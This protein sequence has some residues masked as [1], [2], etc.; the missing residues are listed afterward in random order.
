MREMIQ[1]L[2]QTCL[3]LGKCI[4]MVFQDVEAINTELS[5]WKQQIAANQS[6]LNEER[7][8]TQR[9]LAPFNEQ[10]KQIENQIKRQ[11]QMI[12]EKKAVLLRNEAKT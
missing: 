9:I 11:N 1:T 8:E 2:C 10:L 12:L 4:D 3:P 7:K 6:K 5:K